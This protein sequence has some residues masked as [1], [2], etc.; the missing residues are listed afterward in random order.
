MKGGQR[1]DLPALFLQ[2][3]CLIRKTQLQSRIPAQVST[4]RTRF[5]KGVVEE[6]VEAAQKHLQAVYES[7]FEVGP[8]FTALPE[9]HVTAS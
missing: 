8:N 4:M 9:W 3:Y 1:P 2:I 5:P 7:H 6:Q